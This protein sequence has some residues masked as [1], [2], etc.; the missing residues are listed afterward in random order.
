MKNV[1]FACHKDSVI[2]Q[3]E[4]SKILEE[5]KCFPTTANMEN[6]PSNAYN[7]FCSERFHNTLWLTNGFS[8]PIYVSLSLLLPTGFPPVVPISGT[9]GITSHSSSFKHLVI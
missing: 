6:R 3:M 7:L 5:T 8:P 2:E 1:A 9:F 4:N